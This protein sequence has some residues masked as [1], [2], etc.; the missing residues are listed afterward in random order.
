[1][2]PPLRQ[3]QTIY[4]FLLLQFSNDDSTL[5]ATF[6]EDKLSTYGIVPP[7]SSAAVVSKAL[8]VVSGKKLFV[9][10]NYLKSVILV[11][12]CLMQC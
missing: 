5:S 11:L 9:A 7:E 8:K 2:E 6:P 10:R 12:I 4:N 3:G 1:M